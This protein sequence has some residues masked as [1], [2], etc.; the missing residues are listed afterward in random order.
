MLFPTKNNL[1]TRFAIELILRCSPSVGVDVYI[2]P[3]LNRSSN[4]KKRLEAFKYTYYILDISRM[5][6]DAKEAMGLNGNDKV[7]STNILHVEISGPS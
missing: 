6:E 4:K 7:F 5:V 2:N 1:C 3:G